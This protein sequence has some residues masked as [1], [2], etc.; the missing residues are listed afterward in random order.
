MTEPLGQPDSAYEQHVR[1]WVNAHASQGAR[2]FTAAASGTELELS[3][4]DIIGYDWWTGEGITAKWL[5]RQLDANPNVTLIRVLLD[6]PGGSVFDGVAIHNL[7]K[8]NKARVEIEV[9][10]E[11]SSAASV[12]AMAGDSIKM[13]EGTA[14]MIH[15]AACG[16]WGFSDDLRTAADALDVITGSITDIYETRTGRGRADIEAMVKKE[17]WMSA[18]DAVKE[19]FADEVVKAGSKPAPAH[20]K[21]KAKNDSELD[22][23]IDVEAFTRPERGV[24][25]SATVG[26]GVAV[27][28]IGSAIANLAAIGATAPVAS[29][30]KPNAPP[31]AP[32]TTT[33][34][35]AHH[36]KEDDP[37]SEITTI[38]ALLGLGAGTPETDVIAAVGRLRDLERKA[39]SVTG[40]KSTEEAN[41]A[42]DALKLKADRVDTMEPE[43][44]KIRSDRDKQNFETLIAKGTSAPVKLSPA[45]VKL[46]REQFDAAA[47]EG[48]GAR[49]VERLQGYL[50]V[51]SPIPAFQAPTQVRPASA[52]SNDGPVLAPSGKAYEQLS[53]LEKGRMKNENPEL[54]TMM[55]QDWER[56][57]KPEKAA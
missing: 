47:A 54:F 38:R 48:H 1:K 34:P 43:L 22:I 35:E 41:G 57:G 9:I 55:K 37:M 2:G 40:A 6:S 18:A 8:R 5:K 32:I 30:I 45:M 17:T 44:A 29:N 42:L 19:G 21:S 46:Y 25:P 12:I 31:G 28:D 10:G 56:R 50:N 39:V 26:D 13:H 20:A 52:Q 33:A 27:T 36:E 3:M 15:R 11:A 7:L 51:A 16:C 24:V 53:Y 4:L 49:E 23:E 14:M